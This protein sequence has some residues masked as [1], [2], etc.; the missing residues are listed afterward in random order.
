MKADSRAVLIESVVILAIGVV[1]GLSFNGKMVL[2]AFSGRLNSTGAQP[3]GGEA[4]HSTVDVQAFPLPIMLEEVREL[5]AAGALAVDA[6]AAEV[7]AEGHLPTALSFPLGEYG[8]VLPDFL[9]Q[10]P[11]DRTLILYCSGFGCPDSF[12]LGERLLAEGYLDARVYEGGFPEWR[13]AGLPVEK[14]AP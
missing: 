9:Q 7:Y 11:K 2:D 6:R 4:V 10:V 1:L 5:L 3:S 12:D 13:D 8:Q 14:E